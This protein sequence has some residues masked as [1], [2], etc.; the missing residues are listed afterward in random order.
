MNPLG[1]IF[2]ILGLVWG[3]SKIMDAAFPEEQPQKIKK[4]VFIS[5]DF[6]NDQ[7]LKNFLLGQ[8]KNSKSFFSF[9]DKSFNR[10]VNGDWKKVARNKIRKSDLILFMCGEKTHTATGVTAELEIAKELGKPCYFLKGY[11]DKRCTLPKGASEWSTDVTDW[12]WKN[13]ET[14][15]RNT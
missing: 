11:K 13:I 10:H 4:K 7:H 1:A 9:S 8:A 3:A 14:I 2:S 12:T 5:F 15:L 6:D